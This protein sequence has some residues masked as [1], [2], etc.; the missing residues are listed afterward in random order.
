MREN[1]QDT[2]N[3]LMSF[4]ALLMSCRNG[5]SIFYITPLSLHLNFKS[6]FYLLPFGEINLKISDQFLV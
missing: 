6:E 1:L 4:G 2:A 5:L 3:L